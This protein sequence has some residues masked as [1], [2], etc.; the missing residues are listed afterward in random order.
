MNELITIADPHRRIAA[1]GTENYWSQSG[2]RETDLVN[3]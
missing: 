2:W 3:A 1:M